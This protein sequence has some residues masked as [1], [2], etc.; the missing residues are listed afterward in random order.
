M[1]GRSPLHKSAHPVLAGASST[2]RAGGRIVAPG[3]WHAP[4]AG[5]AGVRSVL[6]FRALHVGDMLC[7]VPALRALR[8]AMPDARITLVGLPWAE[9][10]VRRFG[11]YIDDFLA[12]PGAPGLPEQAVRHAELPGFRALVRRRGYD[13]AVQLH[14]DGA[15][16][17]AV[18]ADFG[19]RACAGFVRAGRALPAGWT[20]IGFPRHG[21]EAARLLQLTDRIGASRH[22]SYL[23]FPLAPRDWEELRESGLATGLAPGHYVCLHPGAR[24]R[25]K[26]WPV[27]RF[28]AV[29]DHIARRW[30]LPV[31]LTGA[32]SEAGLAR[33]V[34]ER[35]TAPA[36]LAA[37]PISLGAM[38]CLISGARLLLC[39]D[40]GVSHIAAA[41]QVR[42]V[43]IFSKADI[44]R[45]APED[46]TL[47]RCLWDP[48]G[49]R[50]EAVLD[51]V[52]QQLAAAASTPRI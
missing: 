45:W 19:A 15:V 27:E 49:A 40:T 48:E 10:F 17:N 2:P 51:H 34:I 25:D 23:E 35:M 9:Q 41:L 39:N 28:A 29:A 46:A 42:S 31:V 6:V 24:T 16:S 38:A 11:R 32:A 52:D 47:H 20:G 50:L 5:L 22:G 43:V 26:C 44:E 18:V 13:L 4:E 14:G 1:A 8:G 36:H 21:S 33:A 37:G 7:A 12:F 30:K 3:G